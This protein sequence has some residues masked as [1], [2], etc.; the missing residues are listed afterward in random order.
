MIADNANRLVEHDEPHRS[1][2]VVCFCL[3]T[4]QCA[5]CVLQSY[6]FTQPGR[7]IQAC[8]L[9]NAGT[10]GCNAGPSLP[11]YS[12]TEHA[13]RELLT[14]TIRTSL[15]PHLPGSPYELMSEHCRTII[16][17][18]QEF[19]LASTSINSTPQCVRAAGQPALVHD[20]D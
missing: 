12:G 11:L 5:A 15:K 6:L 7:A 18:V 10:A 3:N 9:T 4:T 2:I 17:V 14:I 8:V 19:P 16:V 20:H 13:L 1:A